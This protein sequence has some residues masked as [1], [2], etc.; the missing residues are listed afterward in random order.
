MF[1]NNARHKCFADR[2]IGMWPCILVGIDFHRFNFIKRLIN[3]YKFKGWCWLWLASHAWFNFH[4]IVKPIV[5]LPVILTIL[6]Q[7][8]NKNHSYVAIA[9]NDLYWTFV[10]WTWKIAILYITYIDY[11][12]TS[13]PKHK[14][15][16]RS[17]ICDHNIIYIYIYI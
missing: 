4:L 2:T 15:T 10:R 9:I 1:K 6:F 8:Y 5:S 3:A 13:G 17:T 14:T 16:C 12:F 11:C 7:T